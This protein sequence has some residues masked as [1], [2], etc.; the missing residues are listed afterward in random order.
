MIQ[1]NNAT[2]MK[3]YNEFMD[4]RAGGFANDSHPGA[5]FV[6][7]YN[8]SLRSPS[9]EFFQFAHSCSLVR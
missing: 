4:Y 1:Y 5:A 9:D 6:A 3:S 7:E 8:R 2:L